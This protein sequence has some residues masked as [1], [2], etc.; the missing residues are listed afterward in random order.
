MLCPL[1]C[2]QMAAPQGNQVPPP[3]EANVKAP[4]APPPPAAGAVI[5]P[6]N[7]P[8]GFPPILPDQRQSGTILRIDRA[9]GV[10]QLR[11]VIDHLIPTHGKHAIIPIAAP[12]FMVRVTDGISSGE[13]W[14]CTA[15]TAFIPDQQVTFTVSEPVPV[16]PRYTAFTLPPDLCA[17]NVTSP[18]EKP[19]MVL[20]RGLLAT[21]HGHKGHGIIEAH[22]RHGGK[23][24]VFVHHTSLKDEHGA[25]HNRHV[26]PRQQVPVLFTASKSSRHRSPTAQLVYNH[27]GGPVELEPPVETEDHDENITA[28]PMQQ[29]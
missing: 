20:T 28:A 23:A 16:P 29:G 18:N 10:V 9:L 17:M 21:W 13:A 3:V 6:A 14:P 22:T 25:P 15:D 7:P 27:N 5:A 24:Q 8:G 12:M 11:W 4:E 1:A 19:I 2:H 26:R